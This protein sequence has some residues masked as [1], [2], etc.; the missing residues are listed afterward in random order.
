MT[1]L[2]A[3]IALIQSDGLLILF[4][5]AVVEGP[6]ITVIAAY[7]ASLGYLN[8][9]AVFC[10]VV[11]ADLLGD[12]V[13][14]L[15]GHSWHQ[16]TLRGWTPRFGVNEERLLI[17]EE[18]FKRH[19][20]KTLLVGKLTHS[21]GFLVLLAGGASRM[22]FGA[23]IWYNFLGTLLKSSFFIVLGYAFGYA[24]NQIDSYIFRI[25]TIILFIAVLAGVYWLSRKN[26]NRE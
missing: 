17:L 6:I 22:P 13:L 8:L 10:V 2:D 15:L 18:H 25:S 21:A 3:M 23:F 14:Y 20:P 24:Y 4:P 19:G 7:A 11:A 12:A 1:T 16:L 26:R 5:I 9:P